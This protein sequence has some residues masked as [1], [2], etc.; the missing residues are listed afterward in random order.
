[1]VISGDNGSDI[2]SEAVQHP[3][4]APRTQSEKKREK[5][6]RRNERNKANP[7]YQARKKERDRQ[8]RNAKRNKRNDANPEYQEKKK[9]RQKERKNAKKNERNL[10]N[11]EYLDKKKQRDKKRRNAKKHQR[12]RNNP[13]YQKRMKA[14]KIANKNNNRSSYSNKVVE[15]ERILKNGHDRVC[16]CCGQL[17]AEIGIVFNP[18]QGILAI[19]KDPQ[20]IVV[21]QI[22]WIPELQLC[23]TCSQA[24]GKGKVPKLCLAN[25]L[26]FPPIPE[27]LKGL[28]QLEHRLVSARIP[29]MQL[30]E[31][32]PTTQLGIRGN[33]V[34]VPIDIEESVNILPR[35][36]DRTSTIQLAFKRRLQYKGSYYREWVRPHSVYRAAQ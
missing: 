25:G 10:V 12:D 21:R 15:Y 34:N 30:R 26:D 4:S 11:P 27:E 2:G 29:F 22:G 24:V 8:R 23:I 7:L 3:I 36:F 1:M 33:I 17:F 16:V 32:R 13:E 20:L 28:S 5:N 35:E 18:L 19:E 31:L 14:R 9:T 6:R